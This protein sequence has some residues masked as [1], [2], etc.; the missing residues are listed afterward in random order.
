MK[1][2]WIMGLLAGCSVWTSLSAMGPDE[3]AIKWIDR[4]WEYRYLLYSEEAFAWPLSQQ[5]FAK[6]LA[7]E[8][9]KAGRFGEPIAMHFEPA[10]TLN[11]ATE[12]PRNYLSILRLDIN[13]DR[14]IIQPNLKGE[15]LRPRLNWLKDIVLT[16]TDDKPGYVVKFGYFFMGDYGASDGRYSPAICS[17]IHGDS[18]PINTYG[19][20]KP[21]DTP[22][23]LGYFGC[24][25]W[26]AQLY[27]RER[28]Y[29]DVT[30][31]ETEE[32]YERPKVK[33]K[34][35]MKSVNHI[36]PFVGFSRFDSP[37]KPVIGNH[38]GQWYCITDC[39]AG[40]A[41][42]PIADMMAWVQRSGW[43]MPK[44][45]KNVRQFMDKPVKPN[46]FQE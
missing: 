10:L 21:K 19:R 30:S 43:A 41:P 9:S 13:V 27:D 40:D 7:A 3:D 42:G 20:Y 35:P 26:A 37:V 11:L 23:S 24:R 29:I 36:R 2:R 18:T 34:H 33:G 44:K 39:P 28:P 31:Y 15:H 45:P 32:D 4:P 1:S 14:T 22:G 6:R 38:K 25:E 46:A 5:R 17:G 8:P 16:P 12:E